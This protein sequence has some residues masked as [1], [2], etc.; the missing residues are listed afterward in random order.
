M[1]MQ[2]VESLTETWK[3]YAVHDGLEQ[4]RTKLCNQAKKEWKMYLI[5]WTTRDHCERKEPLAGV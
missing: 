4:C 5:N 3:V 1:K 2:T